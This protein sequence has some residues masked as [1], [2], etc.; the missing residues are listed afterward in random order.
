MNKSWIEMQFTKRW[1][2][3]GREG[4]QGSKIMNKAWIEMQFPKM[5]D[6]C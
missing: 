6:G 1:M 5:L 4:D 3:D 2:L